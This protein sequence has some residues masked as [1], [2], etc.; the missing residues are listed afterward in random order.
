MNNVSE[1]KIILPFSTIPANGTLL[2]DC[3]QIIGET[4]MTKTQTE[5]AFKSR[6]D[7]RTFVAEA[8]KEK[9]EE[10]IG[11]KMHFLS[12]AEESTEDNP[13]ILAVMNIHERTVIECE[14][15][16][17]IKTLALLLKHA[18]KHV[19]K[20]IIWLVNKEA[21]DVMETAKWLSSM[22][23]N[24]TK[25]YVIKCHFQNEEA[26]F[27][28]LLIPSANAY[29]KPKAKI[30]DT[31]AKQEQ[32]WQ[33]FLKYSDD[34]NS[35]IKISN[36]A[37]QHWQYISIG[38][39]GVS[40]QLT[41]NTSKNNLGCELLIANDKDLFNKLESERKIIEKH[42]GKLDWQALEGKKSSRIRATLDFNLEDK[43]FEQGIIWMID[44][45]DKFKEVF[46][47]QIT[48]K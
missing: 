27:K 35:S 39:S 24:E 13:D 17:N 6:K 19:A 3:Q 31:K 11:S 43:N 2:C 20:N 40:I 28:A 34:N 16:Q 25:F 15:K 29:Q 30:T 32:F 7:F 14:L 48:G 44:T 5:S 10:I 22:M 4:K 46:M 45:A 38:M 21:P 37:P 26:H 23:T 9:L 18:T 12:V 33:E 36:P 41:I 8:G 47:K 42:L 1:R